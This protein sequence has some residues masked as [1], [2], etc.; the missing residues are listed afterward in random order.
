MN[1]VRALASLA[2]IPALLAAPVRAATT[3]YETRCAQL[4]KPEA[5]RPDSAR[6]WELFDAYWR[7]QMED[8][9]EWATS[10]GYPGQNDRW[11]DNSLEA[12]ARRKREAGAPLAALRSIDRARLSP[13][14]QLNYDLFQR[15]V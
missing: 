10:V 5:G 8:S 12:V 13:E 15:V 4:A 2:L 11:T 7:H 6:L 1:A 9:P 14:D 3:P